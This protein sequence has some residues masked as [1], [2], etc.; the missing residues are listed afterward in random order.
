[1]IVLSLYTSVKTHPWINCLRKKLGFI[2]AHLLNI[3]YMKKKFLM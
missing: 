3:S 2:Q 1:M